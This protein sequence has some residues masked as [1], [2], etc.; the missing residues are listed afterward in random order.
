[1][2][3]SVPHPLLDAPGRLTV[4]GVPDGADALVLSQIARARAETGTSGNM[5]HIARD[6]ARVA[7]LEDSLRF[8]APDIET[9]TLPAWDCLPYD[10]ISPN[11]VICARR[12]ATLS[13]LSHA[14]TLPRIILTTVNAA[15]QR[16]PARD[17][18]AANSLSAK[19]G[20]KLE[21]EAL[22]SF[23]TLAG[24]N[25][26]S[27][28][29]EPGEFAVRGGLVDVFATGADEPV[30][31]DFFGDELDGIRAFD[32]LTQMSSGR[33][34]ALSLM[35]VS[36]ILLDDAAIQRFRQGYLALFGAVTG[37][38]P[39]YEAISEGRKYQGVEH[40]LPLFHERLETVFDYA[41]DAFVSL[42]HLAQEA[43]QSR[44][45]TVD[46]YFTAR[47]AQAT[48]KND[49]THYH[50]LPPD[51]L[52]LTHDE[53]AALLDER[54]ARLF[55]AY[56]LPPGDDVIDY[57]ARQGRDFAPERNQDGVNIYDAL[58]DH[59]VALVQAGKRVL[60][61]AYSEGARERLGLVL[62]DHDMTATLPIDGWADA[63]GLARNVAGLAVLRL[64]SGFE[65]NDLAL[66]TEQDLLGDRLIR[67]SKRSRRAENFITEASSLSPGDYVV[68]L[69][70]GIG[71]FEGLETVEVSGAPHDCVLLTYDGGD[72]LFVPVE[73]IE[74]L[75]RYGSE[76]A[77]VRLDKLGGQAWQSR[78]AQLKERLKEMADELIKMAASREL[79]QAP[80]VLPPQ[81]LYDEFCARFPYEETDDQARAI[82]DVIHDLADGKPMD[83][84]ICGDVGFG[85]TE[86]ALRSAFLAAMDGQQVALI[87][88]T[89]LLVRQ[90]FKSFTERFAGLPVRIEQL[91][92]LVPAPK[93]KEIKDALKD[94][95]VDVIIGTHALLSKN[96]AF[97]D[98]G[99]LII[100]EEQHFGVRHKE[101]LKQLREDVH[102]LTLTAT[103]IPRT[104]QLAM[105][106][107]RGLSL[108]AT[109]PV[110]RLAVRTFVMPF[111]PL[112]IREALLREHY[113][114]GQ[115]YF[116]CPRI[117]DLPDLETFLREDVPEV[118][119]TVAHGQ[120]PSAQ[121]ED[122]MNAF[123]DGQY[124]VLLSTSIIESGL[125]VP[126]ANTMI[127]HRADQFGLAQLYQLRGRVGRSKLRAYAYVTTP[128][129]RHLTDNAEKR[130]KVLQSLDELGAGF[131]L[132]SHDLDIRGAGN[133]LGEE[134]S[135]HI[136]EVGVELYQHIEEAV[137]Q[138]R[139]GSGGE[140]AVINDDWSA[141]VNV[142]AAVLIPEDYIPDLGIRMGFYRRIAALKSREE[143]E[144][145]AAEMIDR[146][147][148]LPAEVESLLQIVSIKQLCHQAGVAKIDAGPRGATVSFHNDELDKP[149]GLVEYLARQSG[150][151]KLRPD[152]TLVLKR[153]WATPEAR[154]KGAEQL[155]KGLAGIATG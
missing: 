31:L 107:L 109:P 153:D 73:N 139:A 125:D 59:L 17:V 137:A 66:I 143:I 20:D 60:I 100:D 147:G 77:I 55:N 69:D 93:A 51:A 104:L 136:R 130:L 2:N 27:T 30:R 144:P 89:T 131:T 126:T 68:H 33:R 102:V 103:P 120:M 99:L 47:E 12:M 140:D 24:Y 28:V 94:G 39:L 85:K 63:D 61:G 26:V 97:K 56:Q 121:L 42:D 38:D 84:L 9:I 57:G 22:L 154:V 114:G 105:S 80:K 88:P 150:T 119:F 151:A 45:D 46:D 145:L 124:D 19:P 81:G 112:T 115:S 35:P 110:D 74:I 129:G 75:S 50:P 123:Y 48:T 15:G 40:W 3:A 52:Y 132:A 72:R 23:L 83:R 62:A 86:V 34:D 108:I 135:D 25:R 133:L 101:R 148:P 10:R 41:P 113:R 116:V 58:R 5:L 44:R 134:Q 122:T 149:D 111:D 155:V 92:R 36:E 95:Q 82:D 141:Q 79:R 65:T 21:T 128:P 4:C 11:P 6:D 152:H 54:S 67:Q 1:M 13:V 37:D 127:I 14:P 53:W 70:H 7:A 78:K 64:E 32:P 96:I 90:H 16:L 146:F 43:T 138:A 106:G 76:D 98:L 87:A 118:K 142:G 117:A 29:S 49:G 8:F 18:V 91:S 71:R